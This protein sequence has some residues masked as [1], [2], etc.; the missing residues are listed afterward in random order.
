MPIEALSEMDKSLTG[1]QE[2][3]DMSVFYS[4]L[5]SRRAG[6][7]GCRIIITSVFHFTYSTTR[8]FFEMDRT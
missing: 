1:H 8:V 2:Q 7:L 3:A 6:S 5:P 4:Q